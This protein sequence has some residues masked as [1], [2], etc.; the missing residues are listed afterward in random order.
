MTA[1]RHGEPASC[2]RDCKQA[3]AFRDRRGSKERRR[4][5]KTHCVGRS[6]A[7]D[8]TASADLP[9]DPAG[10][11]RT[12]RA[13]RTLIWSHSLVAAGLKGDQAPTP[14]NRR[15]SIRAPTTARRWRCGRARSAR[16]GRIIDATTA[17]AAPFRARTSGARA[18]VVPA[19]VRRVPK[20]LYTET[21]RRS[22]AAT[23]RTRPPSRSTSRRSEACLPRPR[24]QRVA[25]VF[26]GAK[27]TANPASAQRV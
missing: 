17:A 1:W 24:R 27:L 25:S 15:E 3:G 6:R 12:A 7:R 23:G 26:P 16:T 21:I 2:S 13:A 5:R 9:P 11:F 19:G 18:A 20:C 14:E 10:S 8:K 4:T 22:P